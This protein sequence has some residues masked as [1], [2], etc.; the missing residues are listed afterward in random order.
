VPH[1]EAAVLLFADSE[2]SEGMGRIPLLDEYRGHPSVRD[3]MV[4][5]RQVVTF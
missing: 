3:L 2:T 5:G 4:E 1:A